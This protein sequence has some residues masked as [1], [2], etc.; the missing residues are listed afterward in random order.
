MQKAYK[1]IVAYYILYALSLLL[2][3]TALFHYKV[4]FDTTALLSYYQGSSDA[5]IQAKSHYSVLK[6]ILPHLMAYALFIMVTLHF[7]LFSKYKE[8]LLFQSVTYM[9]FLAAA[10]EIA[11]PFLI[12][13]GLN[14]F[15]YIKLISFFL[16]VSS[17]LY[18]LWLL[19]ESLLQE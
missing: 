12:L 19:I 11:S 10:F 16:L 6:S 4:G 2:S 15:I 18:I 1:T 14:I 7:L 5:F 9:T 13:T 3:I 8:S 17:L